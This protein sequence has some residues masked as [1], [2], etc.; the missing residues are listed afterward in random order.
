MPCGDYKLTRLAKSD[1]NLPEYC[2]MR[3]CIKA[4]AGQDATIDPEYWAKL[5]DILRRL[6]NLEENLAGNI[7]LDGLTFFSAQFQF[8]Y[9]LSIPDADAVGTGNPSLDIVSSKAE[10]MFPCDGTVVKFLVRTY[11]SGGQVQVALGSSSYT[12]STGSVWEKEILKTVSAGGIIRASII[13]G[14]RENEP[15]TQEEA[16]K[17]SAIALYKQRGVWQTPEVEPLE[18]VPKSVQAISGGNL[19]VWFVPDDIANLRQ[20]AESSAARRR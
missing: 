6:N 19:A 11:I 5:Q 20:W 16:L 9:S 10:I 15:I 7:S 17:D 18:V 1:C 13:T 2:T 14:A 12:S 8:D 3:D 4:K